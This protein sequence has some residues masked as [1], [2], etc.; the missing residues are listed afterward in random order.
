[1]TQVSVSVVLIILQLVY[2]VYVCE[3]VSNWVKLV[4]VSVILSILQLEFITSVHYLLWLYDKFLCRDWILSLFIFISHFFNH[5]WRL[6]KLFCVKF[7][8]RWV[9]SC[10]N[11]ITRI[12][13]VVTACCL[14]Q[15]SKNTILWHFWINWKVIWFLF[16][17]LSFKGSFAQIGWNRLLGENDWVCIFEYF[18]ISFC[19]LVDLLHC[20]VVLTEFKLNGLVFS[21]LDVDVI[22]IVN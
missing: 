12:E 20:W 19:D 14:Q 5:C 2:V 11:R 18:F 8:A 22:A 13:S 7:G 9:S 17:Y 16:I 1:M 3:W 21:F 10:L 6:F 15:W 4:S